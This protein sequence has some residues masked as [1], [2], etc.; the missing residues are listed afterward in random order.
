MVRISF[1]P[2]RSLIRPPIRL[3]KTPARLPIPQMVPIWTRLKFKSWDISLN[4][5]GMQEKGI[6][7]TVVAVTVERA[8]IY[9][10]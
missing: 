2:H 9:Q 7:T 3:T 1:I 4:K 8:N 5:D 6:A 10:R